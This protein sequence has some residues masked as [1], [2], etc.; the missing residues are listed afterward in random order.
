MREG[1]QKSDCSL[2]LRLVTANC[3]V[4]VRTSVCVQIQYTLLIESLYVRV[5]T[6]YYCM[7]VCV[8]AFVLTREQRA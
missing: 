6:A 5:S 4:C 7:C 1:E 3:R 8:S 2:T